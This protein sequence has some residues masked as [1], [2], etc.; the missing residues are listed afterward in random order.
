MYVCIY[1]HT[2]TYTTIALCCIS[3][4]LFDNMTPENL[5]LVYFKLV[6]LFDNMEELSLR[7]QVNDFK[8][9]CDLI[10]GTQGRTIHCNVV[11]VA[12]V[13]ENRCYTCYTLECSL[14]LHLE[15]FPPS[16]SLCH[17]DYGHRSQPIMGFGAILGS[18]EPHHH[19]HRI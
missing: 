3:V 12:M 8:S 6:N 1:I 14:S 7:V 16:L 4:N 11:S 19:L 18:T 9:V 13:R 2:H 5:V 10:L 15:S 17:G